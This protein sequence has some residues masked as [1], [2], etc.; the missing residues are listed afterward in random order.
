MIGAKRCRTIGCFSGYLACLVGCE[1]VT[2][3]GVQ[4][5]L[6]GE[7]RNRSIFFAGSTSQYERNHQG[8]VFVRLSYGTSQRFLGAAIWGFNVNHGFTICSGFERAGA[9]GRK[10]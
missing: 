3:I 7:A 9:P 6:L 10:R 5:H 4:R 2:G 8:A 1:T